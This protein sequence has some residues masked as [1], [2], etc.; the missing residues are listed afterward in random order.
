VNRPVRE[1]NA[2]ILADLVQIRAEEKP[3][4]DVLTFE[5]TSLDGGATPDEV[6]SYADL[7]VHSNRIAAGLIEKGM[8]PGDRFAIMMRNHPEFVEAMIAASITGCV[9]VPI[10]PRTRG[11]KL[12]FLLRNSGCRGVV[13][14]DSTA[15]PLVAVREQAPALEWLL[16]LETGAGDSVSGP[17]GVESLDAVLEKPV[18]RGKS[19]C[20][21]GRGFRDARPRRTKL[22]RGDFGGRGVLRTR[23]TQGRRA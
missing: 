21:D 20:V 6:R 10:D 19:I 12:A 23:E 3:E 9:F 7:Q 4:R 17:S 22:E 8:R 11:E 5:H 18:L 14:T 13:C 2:F 1:R 16:A 15:A